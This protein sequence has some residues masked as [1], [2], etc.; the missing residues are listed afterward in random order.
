MLGFVP[1]SPCLEVEFIRAVL[2]QSLERETLAVD[3]HVLGGAGRGTPQPSV[4]GFGCASQDSEGRR[5]D[6]VGWVE[7]Q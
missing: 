6:D 2:S 5:V 4:E 7:H 3:A 1:F